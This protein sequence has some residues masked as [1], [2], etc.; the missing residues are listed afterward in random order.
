MILITSIVVLFRFIPQ[1]WRGILDFGVIIGL[2]WGIVA[3]LYFLAKY[4][5]SADVPFDGEV[6]EYGDSE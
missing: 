6:V 5:R 3:T 4:W 2:S 1:P